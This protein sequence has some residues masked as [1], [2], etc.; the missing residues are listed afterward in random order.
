MIFARCAC[1]AL[2]SAPLPTPPPVVVASPPLPRRRPW[3]PSDSVL[4][5]EFRDTIRRDPAIAADSFPAS[6]HA[7]AVTPVPATPFSSRLHRPTFLIHS[8]LHCHATRDRFAP[9]R[10]V[11]LI[12]ATPPAIVPATVPA[13]V[14]AIVPVIATLAVIAH[15]TRSPATPASRSA[16]RPGLHLF[17]R[18]SRPHRFL[19]ATPPLGPRALLFADTAAHIM[20]SHRGS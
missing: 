16:S 3:L 10:R 7:V 18:A 11:P 14:P 8:T 20:S 4:L 6:V 5:A 17:I 13:I 9:R 15:A 1:R 12:P 19:A 2:V